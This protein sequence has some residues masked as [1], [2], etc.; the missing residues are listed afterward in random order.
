MT[1]FRDNL[2]GILAMVTANLTFLLNDTQVKLAGDRLPIGEIVFLRGLVASL[3]LGA[4]VFYF[5]LHRY[6]QVVFHRTIMW[7]TV[8]EVCATLLFLT[9]LLRLPIAD[10]TAVLQVVP[11]MTT[12]AG[13]I[14]LAEAVGWRRWTAIAVG[15]IGVLIVLR[16]GGAAFNVFGLLALL[17]MFFVTLRDMATR[18]MPVG[19]PTLLVAAVTSLANVAT[20]AAMGIGEDWVVPDRTALALLLGA[21]V[22]VTVGYYTAILAMRYGDVAVVAPFR[23]SVIVWAIIV[24]YLVWGDVPDL[25]TILGTTIIIAMGVYTFYRERSLA[26]ARARSGE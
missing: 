6:I 18:V 21:G 17:A 1:S 23:Y 25:P 10:I 7:R 24:G 4:L 8:G 20:G 15:F 13:A 16:P 5:G 14:L 12:A 11:L 19:T 26:L 9:A 3:L 22:F 2:R